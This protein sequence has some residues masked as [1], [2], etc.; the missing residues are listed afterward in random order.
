MRHNQATLYVTRE[1]KLSLPVEV[2]LEAADS[3][4]A[5]GQRVYT[6]GFA[7]NKTLISRDTGSVLEKLRYRFYAG[8]GTG[9]H[10]ILSPWNFRDEFLSK[11]AVLRRCNAGGS[12]KK[13]GRGK[14]A[15]KIGVWPEDNPVHS[16]AIGPHGAGGSYVL[17]RDSKRKNQDV[18][19]LGPAETSLD[20]ECSGWRALIR[21]ALTSEYARW[22]KLA[23]KH[24]AAWVREL[25]TPLPLTIEAKGDAP[26]GRVVCQSL[27]D[28][29][30][31]TTQLDGIRGLKYRTC[32]SADCNKLFAVGN[33]EH[34][35]YCSYACAHREAV[36]DGR[37][38]KYKAIQKATKRASEA[39][40]D[41]KDKK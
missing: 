1:T 19:P 16:W 27:L 11:D 8:K 3:F 32:K 22:G 41:G 7:S 13:V 15:H 33:Y 4:V 6:V 31:V 18:R 36:R 10:A 29:L 17:T 21:D 24:P 9:S 23:S 20:Q 2:E 40:T 28:V 39:R 26:T 37:K 35:I 12:I 38:R 5:D 25:F 34:K 14:T 30:I